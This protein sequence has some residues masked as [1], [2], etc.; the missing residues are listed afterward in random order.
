MRILAACSFAALAMAIS[1]ASP[2]AAAPEA[3]C[4]KFGGIGNGV[5]TDIAS[6]MSEASVKN[7]A[8]AWGGDAVK[9]GKIDTK[10]TGSVPLL[11]CTSYG[12][13]CK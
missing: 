13:A 7:Q 11:E 12:K 5:T 6:F 4:K 2:V 8:K 1:A 3:A 10:C 9:V